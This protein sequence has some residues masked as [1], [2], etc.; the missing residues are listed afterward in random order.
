MYVYSLPKTTTFHIYWQYMFKYYLIQVGFE[1]F[2]EGFVAVL[3]ETVVGLESSEDDL[4]EDE[5]GNKHFIKLQ[6]YIV[7]RTAKLMLLSCKE[8]VLVLLIN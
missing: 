7:I 5:K 1:E 6:S 3:S 8:I 4:D 2:K